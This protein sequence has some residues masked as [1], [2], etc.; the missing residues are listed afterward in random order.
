ME[1]SAVVAAAE[2]QLVAGNKLINSL[3]ITQLS[4]VLIK[5]KYFNDRSVAE[6]ESYIRESET[7]HKAE[8]VVAIETLPP[9]GQT[10][11]Q[12]RA[13]EVFGRLRVWDTPLNSGVLL[14]INLSVRT[15]E[16]IADR[17][18]EVTNASWQS[19]CSG[20][21]T[22]F[23]QKQYMIGLKKGIEEITELLAEKHMEDIE[24]PEENRLSNKPHFL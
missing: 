7:K 16:I 3:G 23:A 2:V 21:S 13:L 18:I 10:L 24:N 11:S 6:L 9:S 4:G 1:A 15:I 12:E 20:I 17:G 22:H 8:L 5:R 14:Y 19:V